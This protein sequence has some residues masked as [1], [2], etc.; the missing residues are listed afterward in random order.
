VLSGYKEANYAEGDQRGTSEGGELP[1]NEEGERLISM[2]GHSIA[3]PLKSPIVAPQLQAHVR[4]T[5]TGKPS[6]ARK[7]PDDHVKRP[8]NAFILFRSYACTSNLLPQTLGITDHRQV[9]RVVGQL[10]KGLKPEEKAIWEKKAAEE[11][12]EHKL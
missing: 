6:H 8:R 9:S 4:L 1:K 7:V 12:E 10:W 2:G 5:S 3:I 11:K